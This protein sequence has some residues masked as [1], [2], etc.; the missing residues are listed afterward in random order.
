MPP[1]ATGGR[2]THRPAHRGRSTAA[3]R[4]GCRRLRRGSSRRSMSRSRL[5]LGKRHRAERISEP[6]SV[7]KVL[8][9]GIAIQVASAVGISAPPGLLL[10][11]GDVFQR[12]LEIVILL[13]RTEHIRQPCLDTLY[14]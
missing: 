14:T 10:D 8:S 9:L 13:L 6:V 5:P 2:R 11:G 1:A 12:E 7:V 3:R 4:R